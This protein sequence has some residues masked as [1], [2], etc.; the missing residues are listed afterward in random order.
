MPFFESA[1]RSHLPVGHYAVLSEC[2]RSRAR[3]RIPPMGG[4]IEPTG[5]E[6]LS[7]EAI[8]IANPEYPEAVLAEWGSRRGQNPAEPDASHSPQVVEGSDPIA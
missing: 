6:L 2:C 1:I 7:P 8:E 4:R 3:D 5:V